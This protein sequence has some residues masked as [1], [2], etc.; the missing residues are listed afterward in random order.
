MRPVVCSIWTGLYWQ[1]LTRSPGSRFKNSTI[2]KTSRPNCMPPITCVSSCPINATK[3][4]KESSGTFSKIY[5]LKNISENFHNS[6][7]PNS[8]KSKVYTINLP[9]K[10]CKPP[11]PDKGTINSRP[12]TQPLN[13]STIDWW[14][15]L[16]QLSK[17]FLISHDMDILIFAFFLGIYG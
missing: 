7:R 3:A 2:W 14:N 17:P 8:K 9:K 10:T 6:S 1:N 4:K 11:K 16:L 15:N 12:P 5:K 13:K